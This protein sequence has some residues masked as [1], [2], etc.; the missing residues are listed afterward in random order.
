L[1]KKK[2]LVVDDET[3]I[4]RLLKFALEK[5]G[6]YE[7]ECENMGSNALTKTKS[8]RPDVLV[9]D[10]NLPDVDGGQIAAVIK[11]DPSLKNL[12]IIFLTGNIT[13]EEAQSGLKIGG[14]PA[15]AK[16]INMEML[17]T[18]IQKSLAG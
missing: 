9:L 10:L 8:V 16:P 18:C 15:M 3:S 17:L 11:E 6:F 13:D 5:S 1:A 7:V 4:T 12:P 14:H 2:I